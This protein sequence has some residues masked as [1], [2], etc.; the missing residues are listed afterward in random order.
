MQISIAKGTE[1]PIY[2]VCESCYERIT[3]T[4]VAVVVEG[5]SKVLHLCDARCYGN[6]RYGR[7]A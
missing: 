6:W 3:L 4:H 2:F 1:H 7:A 5:E